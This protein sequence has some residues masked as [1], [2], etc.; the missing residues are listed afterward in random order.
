[1]EQVSW[2]AFL[3]S[4]EDPLAELERV[5]ATPLAI[6]NRRALVSVNP[7]DC[8]LRIHSSL[9]I[10]DLTLLGDLAD[11]A[12]K[13]VR[14]D[15]GSLGIAIGLGS[16]FRYQVDDHAAVCFHLSFGGLGR[17]EI[18]GQYLDANLDQPGLYLPGEAYRCEIRN[19]HGLLITTQVES[20]AT[21]A[22]ILA[23]EAG[24]D[25]LDLSL[26]QRPVAIGVAQD[27]HRQLLGLMRKTLSLLD[28]DQGL[29][30]DLGDPVRLSRGPGLI[31]G[32][33]PHQG[34]SPLDGSSSSSGAFGDRQDKAIASLIC[35][36]IAAMVYPQLV[37]GTPR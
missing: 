33:N 5:L 6:G 10:Q 8:A 2:T 32:Q 15:L 19:P 31:P 21:Q 36:Q 28:V 25:H 18:G 37:V 34:L 14:F 1:L 11:Y 7:S 26:L 4:G 20:I 16:P 29:G 27:A 3:L 24:L 30:P 12:H 17:F 23:E 22:L 13:S 9:P 35:R